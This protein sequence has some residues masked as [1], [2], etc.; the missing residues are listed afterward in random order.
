MS[1]ADPKKNIT[2]LVQAF[3]EHPMLRE[4]ANLVL[5][6]VRWALGQAC[7]GGGPPGE[8]EHRGAWRGLGLGRLM[9]LKLDCWGCC[10]PCLGWLGLG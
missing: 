6:M 9:G 1:R 3:A 4:L 2:A 10:T 5:V 7:A 8:L